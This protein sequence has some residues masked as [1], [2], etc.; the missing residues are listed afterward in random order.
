[1]TKIGAH[2]ISRATRS[3]QEQ[4]FRI[5]NW[6]R[7][8]IIFANGC[9][10]SDFS[11]GSPILRRLIRG[12]ARRSYD[13]DVWPVVL[14]LFAVL[15]PALF[16]LWF[17][18]EAMRN[19]QFAARQKL[20][21]AYRGV[22]S[23]ARARLERAWPD[24]LSVLEELARTPRASAAFARC[25][26][27]G[28]VDSVVILD[29]SGHV[30]YPDVPSARENSGNEQEPQWARASELEYRRN[31]FVGAG[32]LYDGLAKR[33]TNANAAARGWQAAARC[34]V[35]AGER[36][37]A[38]Q[39]ID[40]VFAGK[41]FRAAVDAQDR[42]LA[43]NA[44]LMALE[45]STNRASPVFESMARRLATRLMDYENPALAS[46]QRRFL[47][48]EL[49]KFS[50]VTEIPMLDAEELAAQ[51]NESHPMMANEP[52]LRRAPIPD[53]WQ[54]T[55]PNHRV[56][57]LIGSDKLRGSLLA[58]ATPDNLPSDA[59]LSLLPPGSD[60]D[61]AF[62]VLPAGSRWPGWQLAL[63]FK[64]EKF[65]ASATE[66]QTAVYL[67][68]GMLVVA[69]MS[70]LTLI[71]VRL[72]RRQAALARLK[73]GL[74]ATVSHELKTP[75]A[76]MRVLVDTL[77]DC[78]RLEEKRAREY[79]QLIAQENER[80]SRLIHNFLA[81]S[82]M[83]RK[84]HSFNFA[85]TPV[86]QIIDDIVEAV[87]GRFNAPNCHFEVQIQ[88]DLPLVIAD[89]DALVTAVVNL[90]DNAWKYS[91]DVKVI[92]LA[93]RAENGEVRLSVRDKGIGIA[94]HETR[95]IFGSFYQVDRRLSR[96]GGGCG[97]GLSI[98][99]FIAAAHHGRVSVE[100]Q[101]G[102]GSTFTICLAA[103]SSGTDAG[104][105]ALS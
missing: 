38:I 42:L 95:K 32:R 59:E 48:K 33:A 5:A 99:Q 78:D 101:P 86:R 79:L 22:L 24:K 39:L 6:R 40:E 68:T 41:Q 72:L 49:K 88:A 15:I 52:V 54:F 7:P 35:Q 45:L 76:G 58:M 82:R 47:M 53:Y 1:L 4:S 65:F 9:Q 60:R 8:R 84:T 3:C 50:P 18:S 37:A 64:D 91:E 19:E 103:T 11:S 94:P 14:V 44:E 43:A 30:M 67:W 92:T 102:C 13:S 57:A 34:L 73:N 100:S 77:L 89:P 71:A 56:V 62:S 46:S 63:S 28:Y 12:L 20:A 85:P 93:A 2:A 70:I 61:T 90:L 98:V 105:E 21:E 26:Q 66:H 80:L 27:S 29:D 87:R 16:L 25:V 23:S 74:A 96:V 55:T 36:E 17:M 10:Q 104:K 69:A 83:E 97:L 75:L 51:F 31:D 81:F